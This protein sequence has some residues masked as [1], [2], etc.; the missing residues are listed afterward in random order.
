MYEN[1]IAS[2]LFSLGSLCHSL[3]YINT[4]MSG[5]SISFHTSKMPITSEKT[6]T[7]APHT[8]KNYSNHVL[9]KRRYI[10][11]IKDAALSN[12]PSTTQQGPVSYVGHPFV[13]WFFPKEKLIW[14][15]LSSMWWYK[16][17]SLQWTY[18]IQIAN[19]LDTGV[20]Q[21]KIWASIPYK[22]ALVTQQERWFWKT[23]GITSN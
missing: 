7:H 13:V 12:R 16:R 18:E 19:F 11:N 22:L 8:N 15:I 4:E 9:P 3:S 17:S 10:Q 6:H 23:I 1:D 5:H 14:F 20:L 21:Q 2:V